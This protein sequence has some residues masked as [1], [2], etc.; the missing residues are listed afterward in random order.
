MVGK[1][2]I[3]GRT[4]EGT[5]TWIASTNYSEGDVVNFEVSGPA[6]ASA[7]D[8]IIV[9]QGSEANPVFIF[10]LNSG[11]NWLASRSYLR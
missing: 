2:I 4:G 3:F 11:R 5:H 10:A 7:G 8:Q 6:F 1:L 9:Y